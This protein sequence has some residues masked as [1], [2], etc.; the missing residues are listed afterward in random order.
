M[1]SRIAVILGVL[2]AICSAADVNVINNCN[3]QIDPG[4]FP[5]VDYDGGKTGGFVLAAHENATVEL[6]SHWAGR[7][8]P[9]TGCD[10]EGVCETGSCRGGINCTDPAPAGPTLAQFNIDAYHLDFFNPSTVDGFNVPVIIVPGPG[11]T[12]PP[13]GGTGLDEGNGCQNTTSCPTGV[14]YE[15]VFCT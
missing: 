12:T 14:N 10:N 5:A 7:I 2:T 11:C 1:I 8:W 3:E 15:V 9:R 13:V 6:P 4:F